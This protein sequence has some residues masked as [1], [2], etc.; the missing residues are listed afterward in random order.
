MA[1]QYLWC[2]QPAYNKH[3]QADGQSL[4][5]VSS[6]TEELPIFMRGSGIG[7]IPPVTL[8]VHLEEC[9]R[10]AGAKVAFRVMRNKHWQTHSWLQVYEESMQVAKALVHLQVQERTCV[11]IIGFNS[12]EWVLAFFGSIV[13]NTVA[14]GVYPTNQTEACLYVAK[15]SETQVV[16]AQN[17]M[18]VKKYLPIL[19]Q[20]PNLKAVVCLLPTADFAALRQR[21]SNFYTWT[22]FLALGKAQDDPMPR[23]ARL[24]PAAACTIVYT[25]GT[26]GPPK[27]VMLSHDNYLWTAKAISSLQGFTEA[28]EM[29]SYLPLS[30]CMAQCVDIF[31]TLVLH[32]T[33]TFADDK[34]LQGTLGLTLKA[35]RPTF[36]LGVP[37]V[38][39]KL[40]DA[41]RTAAANNG[42]VKKSIGTWAKDVG[43]KASIAQ[44]KGESP[45]WGYCLAN[46]LVLRKV[47]EALGLDRTKV[48]IA[49]GAPI[50]KA[51]LD[52]FISLNLPVFN[53]YGMSESSAPTTVNHQGRNNLWSAG[54]A[55]PGTDLRIVD[56][57]NNH[58]PA[59]TR[60]EICFRGRNKFLG[61]F[62]NPKESR[63]TLDGQGYI[64][65][66]DEGYLD[67]RGFL[68]ITGRFKELIIT[69]GGENIPPV[70][71]E[72]HLK[73]TTKLVSNVLLVGDA[74]KYLA[75]LITLRCALTPEGAPS[76][77][78]SPEA[79]GI[80]K[81]V[82]CS[83]E[84]VSAAVTDPK[85]HALVQQAVDATNKLAT[86]KAQ[87]IRKWKLVPRDFSLA[88]GE[89]TNTMKLKRKV[90]QAM[91]KEVIE[92]MYHEPKL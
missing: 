5:W 35:I 90:V 61:Y 77:V 79:L 48:L 83:A 71:I 23:V 64:H 33:L 38:Y 57:K 74:R 91:Y 2:S 72:D 67:A 18:Q 73:A 68:I 88:G 16:F 8:Y 87:F 32:S 24:S 59:G 49:G 46:A 29:V 55:L 14:V 52:F 40:E 28:E 66:G 27:G 56:T 11:N 58:L 85:V 3:A 42:A 44:L 36:F 69:A 7:S 89:L 13:A 78:L 92:A 1:G 19:H 25:S 12:P 76:D 39:E 50:A 17:E 22:E 10:V 9:A 60:G 20:L 53:M 43:F 21:H 65:S 51:T 41:I 15:H 26:T 30:H 62:K 82:G 63:E 75:A 45:P 37:R 6:L 31:I 84:T 81:A 54:Y 4:H 47:K 34:A 86:S 70:L 80:L